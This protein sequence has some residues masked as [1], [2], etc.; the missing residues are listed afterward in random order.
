LIHSFNTTNTATTTTMSV[1]LPPAVKIF[2]LVTAEW[3]SSC[4]KAAVLLR[5]PDYLK[6]E[7]GPQTPE[8]LAKNAGV[9]ANNLHI[10]L[11]VLAGAGIFTEHVSEGRYSHNAESKEL[12]SSVRG[13]SYT[14]VKMFA[15]ESFVLP[16][17]PEQAAECIRTGH[18]SF[19]KIFNGDDFWAY[20]DKRPDQRA[21]FWDTMECTSSN[22]HTA[23]L[24]AYDFSSI[25]KIIDVGGGKTDLIANGKN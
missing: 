10:V 20:M 6:E 17:H 14:L 22:F 13:N 11:R 8:Q 3:V 12:L 24:G 5:I 4:L 7:D 16:W 19:S 21:L 15:Q 9:D 25:K 2:N 1:E 23:I 18:R